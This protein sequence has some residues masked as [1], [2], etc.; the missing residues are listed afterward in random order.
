[1]HG[2]PCDTAREGRPQQGAGDQGAQAEVRAVTEA[3]VA[4]GCVAPARAADVEDVGIGEDGLVGSF[5]A[6]VTTEQ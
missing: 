4:G 5:N 2:Q 3:R 1:V 6:A